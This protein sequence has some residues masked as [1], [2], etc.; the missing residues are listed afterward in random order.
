MAN[1]QLQKAFS[2]MAAIAALGCSGAHASLVTLTQAS[3]GAAKVTFSEVS[4]GTALNG[5][6]ING[7]GFSESISNTFVNNGGPGNTGS[8]T[9][10][11]ALGNGNP[12]GQIIS[13]GLP[14]LS[15]AFGFAFALLDSGTIVNGVTITLFDGLSNLGSLGFT[16]IPDPIFPGGFAGIGST[17]A[18]DKATLTFSTTSAAYDLDNF[19][20][21]AA[22]TIVPE[23]GSMVL[24]GL[25]LCLAA[26]G[27][28]RGRTARPA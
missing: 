19:N 5:L 9:Q 24:V 15:T 26:V 18:F 3:F 25:A 2:F 11:S 23:P 17:I 6:T 8:I 7:F 21:I 4:L 14:E 20:S 10:P 16:A 12:V 27:S 13:V 22:P 28:I 1:S